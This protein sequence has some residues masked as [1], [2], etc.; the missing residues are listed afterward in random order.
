M[1]ARSI[2]EEFLNLA[3]QYPIVVL[4]GPRQ[5]GK[6]TLV[7]ALFPEKPYVNLENIDIRKGAI[8][9]PRG[10]LSLYPQ[11]AIL[12][13]VQRVP[14]LLSYIQVIVD[15]SKEKGMFILTGS[16]QLQLHAAITQSLAGRC[17]LLTLYPMSLEELSQAGFDLAL[18][19]LLFRG[20]YPR[21]FSDTLSPSKTYRFYFQTYIEKDLREIAHIHNLSQF[22]TFMKVL[23]SR[24]GQL[25]NL[26]S[27]GNDAGIPTRTVKEWI[28]ILEATYMIVRLQPYF[29]NFGKRQVKSPKIYFT[30]CGLL[31]YLLGIEELSQLERDPIKGF[32][33]ENFVLLE[34]LKA[35][36]NHGLEPNFYFFR[37]SHG[38]EVDLLMQKGRELIP[39]EIKL[40][41][42]YH[43]DFLKNLSYFQS[44]TQERCP[45]GYLLYTG[46]H[47]QKIGLFELLHFRRASSLI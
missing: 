19:E 29:E 37:D 9:D 7:K 32:I 47:E 16:H 5:S 34:L 41:S 44:L 8:D 36:F 4:T 6:T 1:Y 46:M 10:F 38:H 40:G 12:D 43:S 28:S 15:E 42:T 14:D 35:K 17:A 13:E 3:K 20:G 22:Q 25:L 11:G 21:I 26:E 27:L 18:H 24:T 30:D 33:F 2:S 39:I 45:K 31:C 23:A